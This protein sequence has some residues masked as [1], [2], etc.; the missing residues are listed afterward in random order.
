MSLSIK[1]FFSSILLALLMVPAI[2]CAEDISELPGNAD[3][4]KI[5]R[6]A[7]LKKYKK[8]LVSDGANSLYC[9]QRML[10]NF[11]FAGE[12]IYDLKFT[13]SD[14][15]L[16]QIHVSLYTRGDSAIS[17]APEKAA[18]DESEADDDDDDKKK[19]K[20][21]KKKNDKKKKNKDKDKKNSDKSAVVKEFNKKYYAFEK[22]ITELYSLNDKTRRSL[23]MAGVR[24]LENRWETRNFSVAL[25]RG[26]NEDKVPEFL[27]IDFIRSGKSAAKLK[28]EVKTKVDPAELPKRLI[29]DDNGSYMLL[30]MIDQGQKG[31]C[32]PATITRV[33]SYYG[34]DIELHALAGM[35]GVDPKRGITM[36]KTLDT[37]RKIDSKI[38][39]EFKMLYTFP[40]FDP[41]KVRFFIR[42]YNAIA[43]KKGAK[44]L[45]MA[46]GANNSFNGE[47]FT[48]L[49]SEDSWKER[50]RKIVKEHV[51]RGIPLC[52]GVII[53]PKKDGGKCEYHLRLIVG[54]TADNSGVIFS[55]SWGKGH[56]RNTENLDEAW[57]RTIFLF[58]LT[59]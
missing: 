4:W 26:V 5:S 6:K 13:F 44:Q 43:R 17:A 25:S 24:V 32:V 21:K 47:I 14:D 9:P 35:M 31:Y 29:R 46:K 33:L 55:D 38:N 28:Q 19:K 39:I 54:Y 37:L 34:S 20:K 8:L 2:F 16:S 10:K 7:L 1:K 58:S 49:R 36:D 18:P 50:F 41:R 51:D 52:W 27:T 42:R 11:S 3:F 48:Q 53:F 23:K 57:G 56:E 59:P 12:K 45:E 40:D 15:A 30:P 22:Q